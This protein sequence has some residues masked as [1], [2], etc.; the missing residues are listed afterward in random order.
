M[1]QPLIL[2][3]CLSNGVTDHMGKNHPIVQVARLFLGVV[4]SK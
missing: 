4:S 1:A 2:V 3:Q